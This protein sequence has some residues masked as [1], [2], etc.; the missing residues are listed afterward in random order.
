MSTVP[1]EPPGEVTTQLVAE[2]QL[3]AVAGVPPKLA[4]VPRTKPRAGDGDDGAADE[5]AGSRADGAD[6]RDR[7]I[8]EAVGPIDRR[9]ATGRGDRDVDGSHKSARRG[10]R[11][12]RGREQLTPVPVLPNL[13]AVLPATKPVPVMVTTVP[14]TSGPARRADRSDGRDQVKD[15]LVGRRGR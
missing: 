9:G 1:A 11:A 12:Q 10:G 7:V 5:G 2:E 6:R 3:T 15:E 8:G 4:V 14:P 13:A